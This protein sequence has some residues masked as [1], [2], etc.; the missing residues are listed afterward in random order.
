MAQDEAQKEVSKTPVDLSIDCFGPHIKSPTFKLASDA[1][2]YSQ[3]HGRRGFPCTQCSVPL[4][5]GGTANNTEYLRPEEDPSLSLKF[6]TLHL[7]RRS[8]LGSIKP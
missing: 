3:A 5:K 1:K 4:H 6:P 7:E 2:R 8:F